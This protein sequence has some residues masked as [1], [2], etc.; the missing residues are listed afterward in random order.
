MNQDDE[1]SHESGRAKQ[2]P[3]RKLLFW[4]AIVFGTNMPTLPADAGR[5]L[6]RSGGDARIFRRGDLRAADQERRRSRSSASCFSYPFRLLDLL[7]MV[8][9]LSAGMKG[10]I[11]AARLIR[12]SQWG[13]LFVNSDASNV[14]HAPEN[15]TY[16][17]FAEACM[18]TACVMMGG[19]ALGL[20]HCR[21]LKIE[22]PLKRGIVLVFGMAAL[23]A[24]AGLVV[25]PFHLLS[26]LI[27]DKQATPESLGWIGALLFSFAA[28]CANAALAI[29]TI[30]LTTQNSLPDGKW[31]E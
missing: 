10:A 6:G 22:S 5:P 12:R 11:D 18:V 19:A 1:G 15:S 4:A 2:A 24:V 16:I 17:L 7:V 14:V 21:L 23:P 20:R 3:E 9:A 30:A 26:G 31:R 28:T 27:A 25:I 13:W 8:I 29:K